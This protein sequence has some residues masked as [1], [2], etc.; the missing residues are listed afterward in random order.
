TRA[1]GHFALGTMRDFLEITRLL[2]SNEAGDEKTMLTNLLTDHETLIRELRND[3][4][5]ADEMHD[6]GTSDFLT[7]LM[8]KHEKM[9]W[10]IRSHL[11]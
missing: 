5:K 8:E 1:L 2:E 6:P 4:Q 7:A 3:Q 9:A 11:E 10:M